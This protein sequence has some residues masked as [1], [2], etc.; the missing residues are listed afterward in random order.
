MSYESAYRHVAFALTSIIGLVLLMFGVIAALLW[1]GVDGDTFM[2]VFLWTIGIVMVSATLTVLS[3]YAKHRWTIQPNAVRI[4]E[5]PRVP[6][7]GL[8]RRRTLPFTDIAGLRNVEGGFDIAVE[9]VACD[10]K[11]YRIMAQET[12]AAPLKEFAATLVKSIE[13]SGAPAPQVT[14]GLGF[15][16]TA[17]GL[18]VLGVVLALTSVFAFAALVALLGGG[19]NP[20]TRSGEFVAIAV[21]LPFG[22]GYVIYRSLRRRWRVLKSLTKG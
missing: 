1:A 7:F 4:E 14:E 18:G 12:M 8:T 17:P 3:T 9:L 11:T 2:S 15:W 16:N 10:G 5:T 6:F 20:W 21:L 13:A 19:L 22:A